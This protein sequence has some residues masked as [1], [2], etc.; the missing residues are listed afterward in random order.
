M[1]NKNSTSFQSYNTNFIKKNITSNNNSKLLLL[2]GSIIGVIILIIAIYIG[3]S[4]YNYNN[5][6][7][8]IKKSFSDYLFDFSDYNIC[9]QEKAPEPPKPKKEILPI[10]SLLE[11][12]KEVFHIA[13]QDYTYDQA[14]CKCESYGARLATKNEL[15]NAYNNGANWCTYGWTD[16]QTA[17]YPVQQCHW[18]KV[19]ESNERL[20][21]GQQS[22]CGMPGLNGGYFANPSIKFGA[23]CYGI[24]P[25]GSI[26]TPNKPYCPPMNFCKLE[27]NFEASNKLETDEIVGFNNEQWNM[28]L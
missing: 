10:I 20:P 17:F 14:K 16:K 18:N 9:E 2:L 7:C 19:Q 22:F 13:N 23:N 27:S 25:S 15:T 12:K 1:L 24:K 21:P 11:D 5:A 26:V 4:Y 3:V 28:N 8:Y 6:T